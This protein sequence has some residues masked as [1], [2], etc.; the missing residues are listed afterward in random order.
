MSFRLV[1]TGWATEL[2]DAICADHSDVRIISP[3]IKK[4]A[5]ERFL[6]SGNPQSLRVITRFHLGDFSD[7]VSDLGALRLLLENRA[8]IRGVRN[9]H[10]KVYLFGNCRAIVTSANLTEAALRRNHEFGFVTEE[11]GIISRCGQ[12][13]DDLWRRAGPN[14]TL[15]RLTAWE[16]KVTDF[17][18]RG[19]R[20]TTVPG[21]GDEGVDAGVLPE[22]V[23]LPVL[24]SDAR[25][26]FVKFYGDVHNRA[27][28]SMEVV[29]EVRR[30]GSHWACT[31]PKGK[32]PRQVQ[33]GA[34]LFMGRM[35]ND[36]DDTLIYGRA[37][38]LRYVQG[39][40]DASAADIALRDWKERWPHY[41]RVHHPEFVAGDLANGISLNELMAVLRSNAFA[42][43][44]RNAARGKGNTDPRSAYRQQAAV[45]L[46]P[47]A[48]TWLSERL[49]RAFD[50]HGTLPPAELAKLDSPTVVG[51]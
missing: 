3:F 5:A 42:S 43:T 38:G 21:L 35:V 51:P 49:Q 19:I 22:S 15:D 50:Q 28:T 12:Y 24:V 30:S 47:Q 36:P 16:E 39:R 29:D 17:L 7:G 37:V 18:A 2:N 14:L 34:L 32:R 40:D 25:Q 33:D 46:S 13:F 8:D 31:Y 27:A 48:T 26:A 44:Q 23:E 20:S 10:A 4:R 1:D 6:A 9:L 41:V 45:E 11:A